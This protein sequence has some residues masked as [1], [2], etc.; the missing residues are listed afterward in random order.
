MYVKDGQEHVV[1][2]LGGGLEPLVASSPLAAS[3]AHR[4]RNQLSVGVPLYATGLAALVFGLTLSGGSVPW[5]LRGAGAASAGTGLGLIGA[6]FT[7]TVDAVNAY[8]G[9]LSL[10]TSVP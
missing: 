6:G 5:I 2:P 9:S 7:N 8:N 4:G 3:L 10:P 1:G